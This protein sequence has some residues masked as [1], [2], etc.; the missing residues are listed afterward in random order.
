MIAASAIVASAFAWW[1]ALAPLPFSPTPAPLQPVEAGVSPPAAATFDFQR[2]GLPVPHWSIE[3][4]ADGSGHYN[5]LSPT[6]AAPA[7]RAIRVSESV[8]HRL[9]AGFSKVRAGNCETSARHIA[10]TGIKKIAYRSASGAWVS[11][12]FNYSE[13]KGLMDAAA[14]FQEIVETLQEG[15]ALEHSLRFD[16]LGLDAEIDEFTSEIHSGQAIEIANIAPVLESIVQDERVMDRVR[17]KAARL[18]QDLGEASGKG[19]ALSGAP[20]GPSAPSPRYSA[21]IDSSETAS[22]RA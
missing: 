2:D 14:A 20:A 17:R 13:D 3:I 9:D 5:D 18:L 16:R 10:Q 21:A 22:E 19:P 15:D 4:N 11:C 8:R 1:L 7:Q 6:P 12:T